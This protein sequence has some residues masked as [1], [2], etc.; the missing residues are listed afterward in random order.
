MISFD[1]KFFRTLSLFL[2]LHFSIN[3]EETQVSPLGELVSAREALSD[4]QIVEADKYAKDDFEKAQSLLK[5]AESILSTEKADET[6][7]KEILNKSIDSSYSAILTSIPETVNSRRL[8]SETSLSEAEEAFSESLSA[9]LFQK[10][11][12]IHSEAEVLISSFNQAISNIEEA[13]PEKKKELTRKLSQDGVESIKKFQESMD[14]SEKAKA[15]SLSQKQ[16]LIDSQSDRSDDIKLIE[17]IYSDENNEESKTNLNELQTSMKEGLDEIEAG[18]MKTGF[19]KLESLR[20]KIADLLA[21]TI[22]PYAQKK[23]ELSRANLKK[24]EEEFENKN[25][26]TNYPDTLRAARES[27]ALAESLIEQERYSEALDKSNEINEL[28]ESPYETEIVG[29]EDGEDSPSDSKNNSKKSVSKQSKS[30]SQSLDQKTEKKRYHTV[31]SG[32]PRENLWRLSKKYYQTPLKW[33]KIYRANR[34]ILKS[35][36]LLYPGQKLIIP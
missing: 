23:L 21:E 36:N 11:K 34:R 1:G 17:E 9:E 10:S 4:A 20:D 16:A 24:F 8:K 35:P 5:E 32:R 26:S 33:K 3:S 19:A 13:D 6:K 29:A 28:L 2:L 27:L 7:A 14:L 12:E 25:N 15:L 30:N 31:K 22:L 18:K